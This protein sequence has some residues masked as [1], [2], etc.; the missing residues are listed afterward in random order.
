M[1]QSEV[2]LGRSRAR[3]AARFLTRLWI[4]VAVLFVAGGLLGEWQRYQEEQR[5]AFAADWQAKYAQEKAEWD[6][7]LANTKLMPVPGMLGPYD[8]TYNARVKQPTLDH[9]KYHLGGDRDGFWWI[10]N[11][12]NW[13]PYSVAVDIDD[14]GNPIQ[15]GVAPMLVEHPGNGLTSPFEFSKFHL[16]FGLWAWALIPPLMLYALGAV[17]FW[18][19]RALWE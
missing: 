1:A 15:L 12:P 14:K 13:D 16:H 3:R 10:P 4:I 6:Q 17:L 9:T 2:M 18:A 19:A 11:P 7:R 8:S 5:A